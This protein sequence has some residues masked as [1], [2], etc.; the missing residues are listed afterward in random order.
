MRVDAY[1]KVVLTI[2]AACLVWLCVTDAGLTPVAAQGPR[3]PQ[4]VVLFGTRTPVPVLTPPRTSLSM[5]YGDSVSL[6]VRPGP[7]WDAK[8]ATVTASDPL[9]AKLVGIERSKSDHWDALDVNV[10]D[11]PRKGTPGHQ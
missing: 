11:Q 9:P 4:E 8:P 2:I 7:E 3:E 6:P 10:K 5:V 1:T